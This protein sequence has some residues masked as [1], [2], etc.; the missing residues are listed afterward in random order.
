MKTNM[1]Y[2]NCFPYHSAVAA[3][4]ILDGICSISSERQGTGMCTKHI[5]AFVYILSRVRPFLH[6]S[7]SCMCVHKLNLNYNEDV[8]MNNGR[9]NSRQK[10]VNIYM[11]AA[12][13]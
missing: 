10:V 3:K 8:L 13:R 2:D 1:I 4:H 12:R 6:Q 5:I 9:P 7:V 11:T